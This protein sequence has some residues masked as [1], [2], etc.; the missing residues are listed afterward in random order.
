VRFP[1]SPVASAGPVNLPRPEIR[2]F[3]REDRS[4]VRVTRS[5]ED[6][7][8]P[9]RKGWTW[10]WQFRAACRGEDS[11]LFFA[12]N[13]FERRE[14]KLARETRAKA[15]CARCPVLEDCLEYALEVRENHGVWGGLNELERRA[16]LRQR[17]RR[18][19]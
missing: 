5:N 18:A 7:A 6:V 13:Y 8:D 2:I 16:V 4:D 9:I 3:L 11:S 17:E 15:F 1:G 14:E 10:G 12:P 19:G